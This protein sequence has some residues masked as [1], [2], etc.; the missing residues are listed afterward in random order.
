MIP[1]EV[2]KVHGNYAKLG[3]GSDGKVY[4]VRLDGM[5]SAPVS[6]NGWSALPLEEQYK[7]LAEAYEKVLSRIAS[8]GLCSPGARE[9]QR[10]CALAAGMGWEE[11]EGHIKAGNFTFIDEREATYRL[12]DIWQR[13]Q[14]E[15]RKDHK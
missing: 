1:P 10:M 7:A 9:M 4:A 3:L 2:V 6:A 8:F 12:G 11:P 5:S 13:E 14:N 15:K